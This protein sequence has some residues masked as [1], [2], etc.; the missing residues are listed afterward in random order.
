MAKLT[1]KQKLFIEELPKNNWNAT[2]A[3]IAAGYSKKG[4]RVTACRLMKNPV[5]AK[6]LDKRTAQIAEKTGVE[7]GEIVAEIRKI[8]FGKRAT[9]TEKLRAL[10]LLGKHLAMFT[11]RQVTEDVSDERPVTAAELREALRKQEELEERANIIQ[12]QANRR[13]GSG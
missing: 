2:A 5:I 1:G 12:M 4:V 9:N 11:D 3:C 13:A 6:E 8:A 10:E 7:V